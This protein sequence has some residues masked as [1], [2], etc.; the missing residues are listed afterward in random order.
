VV[1][2]ARNYFCLDG[3]HLSP[4]GN[5]VRKVFGQALFDSAFSA[6]LK[7]KSWP[8]RTRA[9][10]ANDRASQYGKSSLPKLRVPAAAATIC[11]ATGASLSKIHGFT[12]RA[13]A[14]LAL[15]D[16]FVG[17]LARTRSSQF[18]SNDWWPNLERCMSPENPISCLLISPL[19]NF[20]SPVAKGSTAK[21]LID[22][23]LCKVLRYRIAQ[24]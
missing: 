19:S 24:G 10:L 13:V 16:V 8:H 2:F 5:A 22:D 12:P 17:R 3:S 15:A 7:T 4:E 9:T 11:L 1:W 14:D 21:S 18:L 20:N 6:M 23:G